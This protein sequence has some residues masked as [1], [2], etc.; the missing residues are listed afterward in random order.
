[1]TDKSFQII[2]ENAKN[3]PVQNLNWEGKEVETEATPLWNDDSGKPVILRVFDFDL[4]PIKE[5]ELPKT[6]DLIKFHKTKITG[7]LWRDELVP[8]QELK[9]IYS[10]DK[11]HFRIFATCQAKA[12]STILERPQVLQK[13]IN[14][15]T[16]KNSN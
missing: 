3:S 7:F 8:I 12:G 10:K 16:S 2:E 14:A 11:Q 4:P 1:M 6:E 15:N 9:A 13:I 5:E